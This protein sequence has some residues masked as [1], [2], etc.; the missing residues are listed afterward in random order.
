M[1]HRNL[2]ARTHHVPDTA[3]VPAPRPKILPARRSGQDA[4]PHGGTI[5]TA[6]STGTQLT[7]QGTAAPNRAEEDQDEAGDGAVSPE[8]R[9]Q[10]PS[11]GRL[12][13]PFDRPRIFK[14]S[15]VTPCERSR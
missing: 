5:L 9:W 3:A 15:H 12:A 10:L 11:A 2:P 6:P 1:A 13:A 8:I 14:S 4:A 7:P